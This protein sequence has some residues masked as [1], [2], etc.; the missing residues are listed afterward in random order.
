M[1]NLKQRIQ[2]KS[3]P[4]VHHSVHNGIAKLSFFHP[5]K[6]SL[7]TK[8]LNELTESIFELG[9]DSSVKVIV[10]MSHGADVFCAGANFTEM[11][12]ITDSISGYKYFKGF[13]NLFNAIRVCPK[14]VI[15]RVQG[16]AV[17]GGVGLLAAGDY[18]MATEDARFKLSDFNIGIGP[19]VIEPVIERKIGSSNMAQLTIDATSFY[20]TQWALEKGL[21]N[22]VYK[23]ID[24]LDQA[25]QKFAEKI[26]NFNPKAVAK[27]KTIFWKGTEN[28]DELLSERAALSGKF[29]LSKHTRKA[30][31][32]FKLKK[33][34]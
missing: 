17:G 26:V 6:N 13:S 14:I 19:F 11:I 16:K 31:Q 4:F 12:R 25:I 10:L 33:V 9:R 22:E 29:I 20:S 15:T 1:Y 5:E 2:K 32:R 23:D 7:P 21:F 8:V 27:M 30:L 18:C 24:S 3:V 34:H 28:W